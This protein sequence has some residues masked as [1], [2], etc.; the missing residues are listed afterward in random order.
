VG[1][2]P[3]NLGRIQ[4]RL[5]EHRLFLRKRILEPFSIELSPGKKAWLYDLSEGGL[6]VY[7]GSGLDLGTSAYVRFQ[8]PEANAVIDAFGVVAWSDPSGRAGIRFTHMQP[9]S[10]SGLRRWLESESTTA[11]AVATTASKDDSVLASR[12]SSLAQ[13]SDLQAKISSRQVDREAALDLIVRRMMEVTRA[14]G[15]AI[16]L[17][18]ADDVVCRASVGDAPD[19]GVKLS[20]SSLSGECFRTGTVVL[21]SDSESDSRVDPEVCRQLNFRSLLVLPITAGEESIGIAEVLS[22]NPRNFEGGD[23]LVVSFLAEMIVS[24]I[25]PPKQIA[26]PKLLEVA[27]LLSVGEPIVPEA[28][29]VESMAGSLATVEPTGNGLDVATVS[30]LAPILASEEP[31]SMPT[32]EPPVP[33]VAA[34]LPVITDTQPPVVGE[35]RA[36]PEPIQAAGAAQGD[37]PLEGAPTAIVGGN[38]TLVPAMAK[39]LVR[40]ALIPEAPVPSPAAKLTVATSFSIAEKPPLFRLAQ[41][42]KPS[43]TLALATAIVGLLVSTGLLFSYHRRNVS[44]SPA[45]TATA[46]AGQKPVMN[47]APPPVIAPAPSP[48]SDLVASKPT[49]PPGTRLPAVSMKPSLNEFEGDELLVIHPAASS[50]PIPATDSPAP[51][52]PTIALAGSGLGMLPAGVT[53]APPKPNLQVSQSQGVIPG[54]LLKKVA[55]QYPDLALRAGLSGDVVLLA[56]I[57]T[58]GRLHHV[59]AISGSPMLREEAVAAA[60]QWRYAPATLSGKPVESDTRIIINFTINPRH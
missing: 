44:A 49:T 28:A 31:A 51:E 20:S 13:V 41:P 10:T 48:A 50:P 8:F 58:D 11:D 42:Q 39:P 6:R 32:P 53:A 57:G 55:P 43:W 4:S 17:R 45:P 1:T 60:R 29:I 52:A 56:V 3:G 37:V 54:R 24:C 36:L 40:P 30:F 23:I 46:P 21:L 26:Q 9:E 38:S 25:E 12:I 2:S 5:E 35:Q 33:I 34:P 15:A 18:E 16:A 47:S 14:S 27:S 59:K 19:V 7:G 22:P